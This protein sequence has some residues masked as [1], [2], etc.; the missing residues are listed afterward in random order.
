MQFVSE[1][2]ANP[3]GGSGV[4]LAGA[5]GVGKTRLARE[6]IS[7]ARSHGRRCHWVAAT[8]SGAPSRWVHSLNTTP[9]SVPIRYAVSWR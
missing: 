8:A 4:V 6:A 1:A 2:I 7:K 5:A 9:H 3:N